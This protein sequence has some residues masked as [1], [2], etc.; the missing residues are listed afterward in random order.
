MSDSI[1]EN[2]ASKHVLAVYNGEDAWKKY[3]PI[4]WPQAS[5]RASVRRRFKNTNM[6]RSMLVLFL[7]YTNRSPD[8]IHIHFY[9]DKT[10]PDG[11][12]I[13]KE[14]DYLWIL[15]APYSALE[16]DDAPKLLKKLIL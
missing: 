7:T 3:M 6:R 16:Y 5:V 10:V 4:R 9:P 2:Y 12:D 14:S 15:E 11:I 1:L 13:T 8:K